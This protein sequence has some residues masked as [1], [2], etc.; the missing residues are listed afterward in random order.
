MCTVVVSLSPGAAWPVVI[1]ANRDE[2]L[3]R[4]WDAPAP[5]WPGQPEVVGG[6]DRVAG[7][8]WM[9]VRGG[10]VAAVLNRPGSLGPAEGFR[11]RGEL[12]LLALAHPSAA[13]A[14]AALA[15]A[16]ASAWRPFNLVVT[17]AGEAWLLSGGAGRVAATRLPDGVSMITAVGLD[18]GETA[19]ARLHAPR[20]REARRP[21]PGDHAEWARLLGSTEAEPGA[22]PRGGL[23][24]PPD[25]GYGT[26]AA[27][28][29]FLAADGSA[30]V[31]LF[32]PGPSGVRPFAAVPLVRAPVRREG[33]A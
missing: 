19:R 28:L 25:R 1:A 16:D 13:S 27:S 4:P 5:H 20:F 11:S 3:D 29:L 18:A 24:V 10:M 8:T 2:M 6:R 33:L 15:R 7:G 9:A 17:D 31:W 26:V 14:A 22:G 32:A 21:T 30:P 23:A 12:P